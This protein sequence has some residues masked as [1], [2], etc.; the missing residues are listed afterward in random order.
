MASSSEP[1]VVER[2]LQGLSAIDTVVADARRTRPDARV[3]LTEVPMA[4][5]V[6]PGVDGR[7]EVDVWSVAV[8]L[9]A[10]RTDATEV[11]S[12]NQVGLTWE[13]GDWRV[14]WWT[15]TPGPTPAAGRD[16]PTPT[17]QVLAAVGEWSGYRHVPVG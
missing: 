5:H 3:L 7:V 11:W 10:G 4:H 15:R 14:A 2:G 8:V 17:D 9:V 1:A 12:T 6:V 13:G 16:D